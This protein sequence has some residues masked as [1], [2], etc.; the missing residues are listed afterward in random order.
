MAALY[1]ALLT[2]APNLSQ[3]EPVY[4]WLAD[5][6]WHWSGAYRIE[7]PRPDRWTAR[8]L[9]DG[10]ALVAATPGQLRDLIMRDYFTRPVPRDLPRA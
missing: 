10:Q 8:R 9:D 4:D 1:S 2:N 3:V 5:L 7:H 6:R